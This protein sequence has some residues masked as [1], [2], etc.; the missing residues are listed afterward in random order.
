ML[1]EKKKNKLATPL[2]HNSQ[3][4]KCVNKKKSEQNAKTKKKMKT[5]K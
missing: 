4:Y 3:I 1:K 2:H 5:Q